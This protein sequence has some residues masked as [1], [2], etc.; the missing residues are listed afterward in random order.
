MKPYIKSNK[1]LW[2]KFAETHFNDPFYQV[3]AF[4]NGRNSLHKPELDLLGQVQNRSVLH[5]QC[6]FGVDSLSL[7][8]LGAS[9]TGVDFSPKAISLARELSRQTGIKANFIESDVTS[10]DLDQR[11]DIVYISYGVLTWLNDLNAWGKT[12]ARHLKEGGILV[13]VEFHP[14]LSILDHESLQIAHN[15]FFSSE[16]QHQEIDTS[17]TGRS[18]ESSHD[19]FTWSHSLA[20]IIQAL[21]TA[22]FL[23]IDLF[24]LGVR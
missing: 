13:L 6:H 2:D 22:N 20:S 18:I 14:L 16:P 10:I 1:I 24:I 17:Y 23:I 4:I 12:V 15:Y 3:A 7:A 9:V 11:F 8:R 21:I 19:E 5:L